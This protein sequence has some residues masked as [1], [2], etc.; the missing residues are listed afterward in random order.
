[1]K[2]QEAVQTYKETM[3]QMPEKTIP[4]TGGLQEVRS[5]NPERLKNPFPSSPALLEKG[6]EGYN[7]YCVA[8][9]GPGGEG[10]GTVGQSFAPLPTDLRGAHVQNQSDGRLFYTLTFGWK[11]HPALGFMLSEED[12]LTILHY[13]RSLK[14]V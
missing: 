7:H 13:I 4:F 9:H 12:R 10:R 14:K 8:C 11:R 2:N 5:S 3:P 6:K 1:M